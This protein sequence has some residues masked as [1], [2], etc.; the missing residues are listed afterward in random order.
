[1]NITMHESAP[2]LNGPSPDWVI[3]NQ[4]IQDNGQVPNAE[5]LH[6]FTGTVLAYRKES[7]YPYC[8]WSQVWYDEGTQ[9]WCFGN[10]SYH[11]DLE[12]ARYNFG[13]NIANNCWGAIFRGLNSIA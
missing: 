12:L 4:Y 9:E 13:R 11:Q 3:I 7:N 5:G 10:G 2:Q 6:R 1:M 8:T